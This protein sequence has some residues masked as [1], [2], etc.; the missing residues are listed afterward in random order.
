[1]VTVQILHVADP[2]FGGLV[3]V[4][5]V[6]ALERMIPDL[7]PDVVVLA[8]DLCQRAR[9]G[10]FQR[11]RAFLRVATETA[12]VY[13]LPGNH[14][15][16]WWWRPLVPF[17][18]GALYRK[19]RRYLGAELAPTLTVPGATIAG[20]LTAHGVAWGSLSLNLRD[21]AVKGHL[22]KGEFL[23]AKQV[24]AA[25]PAEDARVLVVHHNVLR[26][27]ISRRMGL[28][29]W[30]QAQRRIVASGAD[31]V[32][33]GHDH[34]AAADVL[35][36]KVVVSTAGT[37]CT[38][39]RGG[40]PSSFNFVTIEPTAVQVAFFRWEEER[41][42]FLASDTFAFAHAAALGTPAGSR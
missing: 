19:Y 34:Q 18:R 9:H 13:A 17:G 8:G 5:Q 42:R 36:G 41:G 27:E 37:L 12:P 26:G 7:H 11:A 24:F 23:R 6:E 40:R 35:G 38:R 33:C 25:A 14:D 39:A 10:E 28:V 32:L 31:V 16:C 20:A 4:R 2:H 15:V 3:G 21:L 22:P 30:R 29:R 1:M